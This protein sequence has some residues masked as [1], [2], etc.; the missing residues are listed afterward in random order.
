MN[1]AIRKEVVEFVNAAEAIL[2]SA[3]SKSSLTD[4]ERSMITEYVHQLTQ[5]VGRW[6][7]AAG[8]R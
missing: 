3:L 8:D 7:K 5:E 6:K 1:P 4:E 2:S